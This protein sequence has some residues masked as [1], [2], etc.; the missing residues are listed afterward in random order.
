LP[1]EE[2]EGREERRGMMGRPWPPQRGTA[3]PHL[4]ML[5]TCLRWCGDRRRV[6]RPGEVV[7]PVTAK[8][9]QLRVVFIRRYSKQPRPNNM[10][11]HHRRLRSSAT[12]RGVR[13]AAHAL[14][15]AQSAKPGRGLR[16][17]QDGASGAMQ[18][19]AA[20]WAKAQQA[21]R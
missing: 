11:Q 14:A 16:V 15:T 13:K 2:D 8:K 21:V 17:L 5:L 12:P 10:Q 6:L 9:D 1:G 3:E 19:T 20:A 4:I 7:M 18:I